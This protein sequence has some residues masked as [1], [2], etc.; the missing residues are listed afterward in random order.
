M[1]KAKLELDGFTVFT[2]S[3]GECGLEVIEVTRPDLI[4]LDIR[5]PI[6][7][8]DEML[9]KLRAEDWGSAIRVIVLTNLSKDEAPSVLRFLSVDR[10]VV[11]A[12]YTP[13]QIT[14]VAREVL[15]L[16]Y[17]H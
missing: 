1:Y 3:D 16:P 10:Y 8:G 15:H 7:S 9:T 4:L 5:M 13:A 14:Q 2:A 17:S 12:H 6:M 11:K